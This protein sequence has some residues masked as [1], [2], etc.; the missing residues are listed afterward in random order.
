[1]FPNPSPSSSI[2]MKAQTSTAP[3]TGQFDTS[4]LTA[5][6]V[7]TNFTVVVGHAMYFIPLALDNPQFQLLN[8]RG[9]Y[10]PFTCFLLFIIALIMSYSVDIFLF[11][12]GF[13][14]AHTFCRKVPDQ[15]YTWNHGLKH[16]VNRYLRLFPV[17]FISWIISA[18]RGK[19]TCMSPSVL[20]EGFHMLNLNP[21]F[22][23][24]PLS[25]VSCVFSAWS[26]SLD[27]QSHMLMALVLILLKSNRR[28]V[29]LLSFSVVLQIMLRLKFLIELG[30]PLSQPFNMTFTNIVGSQQ[31]LAEWASTF[32]IPLRNVT[33]TDEIVQ[34]SMVLKYDMQMYFSLPLRI[35]PAFIG[36]ITWYAVQERVAIVRW[37]ERDISRTLITLTFS[38]LSALTAILVLM[39]PQHEILPIWLSFSIESSQ[40]ILLIISLA[41]FVIVVGNPKNG[42]TNYVVRGIRSICT[43]PIMNPIAGLSY[44]AY[45]MHTYL[46]S[47]AADIYPKFSH[48]N[49]DAWRFLISGIQ[50]YVA[51]LLVALP[52]HEFEKRF[53]RTISWKSLFDTPLKKAGKIN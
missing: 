15:R 1:M 17:Y 37:M 32:G 46:F 8:E 53:N 5:V 18:S 50:I 16:I 29:Q 44:A 30:R 36:F 23:N 21:S 39:S 22:A 7:I 3:R 34:Q 42:T 45:L 47:L 10:E 6:R 4:I 27:V 11:L 43:H 12:S 49:L 19:Q 25:N 28:T 51:S 20:Y 40:R 13:L 48:D 26:M 38:T 24:E 33:I 31:V 35:A 52:C 41:V 2:D 9:P 14:F